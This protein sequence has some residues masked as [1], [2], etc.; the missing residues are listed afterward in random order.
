MLTITWVTN[1]FA[2][3][4]RPIWAHLAASV[5]LSVYL[6]ESSPRDVERANR[7]SDWKVTAD[8]KAV[9][10]PHLPKLINLALANMRFPILVSPRKLME[11]TDVLVL[12]GWEKPAYWQLLCLARVRRRP[13]MGFY[14]STLASNRYKRGPVAAARRY[15][16]RRLDLVVAPGPS[17]REALL[18][19]GVHHSRIVEGFNTVDVESMHR[20]AEKARGDL[21]AD[22]NHSKEI[23]YVGQLIPRKNVDSLI[24]AIASLDASYS[25]TILGQGSEKERLK[26]LVLDLAV[27]DRVT[28]RDYADNRAVPSVLCQHST[29]VLPSTE[30]VWGLVANEALACGLHVVVST[31]CGVAPSVRGMRGVWLSE[32]SPESI[33]EQIQKSSEN[34][35]GPIACPEILRHT[36]EALAEKFLVASQ[37]LVGRDFD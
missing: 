3:Y 14:A 7:G 8:T 25:L 20:A 29:L 33:A 12:G 9:Y 1:R 11:G 17:A 21:S 5:K 10:G 37:T 18:A 34:W 4:R 16:F 32:T 31:A 23:I 28:F 24:R 2:P 15:F 36:P 26:R 13:V 35:A 6:L 27:S 22:S 19:F 30:E